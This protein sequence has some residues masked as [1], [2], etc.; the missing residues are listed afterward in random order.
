MSLFI[1]HFLRRGIVALG[2]FGAYNSIG[3]VSDHSMLFRAN[4]GNVWN[5][6][7]K[8]LFLSN[9]WNSTPVWDQFFSCF[10]P[11]PSGPSSVVGWLNA[12]L[13]S[14]GKAS[15]MRRKE[16]RLLPILCAAAAVVVVA[17]SPRGED[18]DWRENNRW[19][20]FC[21]RQSQTQY[22][23]ADGWRTN[24]APPADFLALFT[25]GRKFLNYMVSP[26]NNAIPDLEQPF[27]LKLYKI[28]THCSCH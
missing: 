4:L 24:F 12:L 10:A 23:I 1:L 6:Y 9:H 15:G 7:K 11:A 5:L 3:V 21:G 18:A 2:L 8:H 25:T 27:L 22:T 26:T 20:F 19:L 28:L 16:Q 13:A 14:D 17:S